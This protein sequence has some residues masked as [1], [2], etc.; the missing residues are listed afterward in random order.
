MFSL[1]MP[2]SPS[3]NLY[4]IQDNPPYYLY[5]SGLI[6]PSADLSSVSLLFLFLPSNLDHNIFLQIVDLDEEETS[7]SGFPQSQSRTPGLI[8]PSIS[9]ASFQPQKRLFLNR[10]LPFW[11]PDRSTLTTVTVF[12]TV[13]AAVVTT[14]VPATQFA[15]GAANTVCA[16]RKRNVVEAA[17]LFD[18][19]N[20]LA[21]TLVQM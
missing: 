9:R 4:Q 21:P 18:Y 3:R 12:S 1:A 15:L 19:P 16:R 6:N 13:T 20:E 14:C 11:S 2:Y 8:Y 5:D 10:R 7:D 17:H